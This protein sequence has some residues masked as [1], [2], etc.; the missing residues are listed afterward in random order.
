MYFFL[1]KTRVKLLIAKKWKIKSYLYN[2]FLDQNVE[3]FVCVFNP[4]NI[5]TELEQH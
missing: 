1:E 4:R 3:R 5:N 2:L